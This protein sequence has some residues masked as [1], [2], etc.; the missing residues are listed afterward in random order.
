LPATRWTEVGNTS[1]LDRFIPRAEPV[2]ELDDLSGRFV[3][4]FSGLISGD[5]GLD[6]ALQALDYLNERQPGRFALVI[7]GEGPARL[8]LESE[9]ARLGLE[10][11]VRFTGWIEHERLPDVISR[12]QVG[13]LPFHSCAHM[14]ATLANKL[15]EY[16]SLGLPVIASD[17]VP[18]VRV[19]KEMGAG[20]I[21]RSGDVRDLAQAIQALADNRDACRAHGAAGRA[22]TQR[23]YNWTTDERRLLA[24]IDATT[25][26]KSCRNSRGRGSSR[27]RA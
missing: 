5:R 1:E 20:L 8:Q 10:S 27:G 2:S 9:S 13:L 23:A 19:V 12:A 15:F 22:A 17:M 18:M 21:F 24:A 11:H 6:T 3:L 7:V 4:L 16:T 25:M 14:H 26:C